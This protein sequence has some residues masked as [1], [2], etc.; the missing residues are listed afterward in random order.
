MRSVL[1]S[2]FAHRPR[3]GQPTRFRPELEPL[4]GR[5]VPSGFRQTNLVADEPG[6]APLTDPTLVNAWGISLSPT[7]GAFWVSA[8]GTGI[9]ALYIGDVNGSAV[10]RPFGVTV[11]GGAPT[12]QVFNGTGDFRVSSGTASATALF[13]FAT[14]TGNITGWN[15]TVP[16]PPPS[17]VAQLGAANPGAEY[18]GLALGNNGAGNFLYA[19]DFKGKKIDVFNSAFAPTALAGNF[20]DPGIPKQYAPFN[21]QNLGGKLYVTYAKQDKDG[22]LDGG[23]GFVSV[24]DLN[25]NFLSRLVSR[26]HLKEPWGLALAPANFGDF[27]GALLVGNHGDGSVNA[28]DPNTGDFLGKLRDETG[29]PVRID[30]LFGLAFGNG[31][32]A[33]DADALYFAAGPNGGEDGLFGKLRFVPDAGVAAG[34]APQG[35]LL[36]T[37]PVTG[38][39][40][41]TADGPARAADA[42]TD[43]VAPIPLHGPTV[44]FGAP[45]LAAPTVWIDPLLDLGVDADPV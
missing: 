17:L 45:T 40:V 11:P 1:R 38:P 9:S 12:G 36:P 21:I 34:I 10:A 39:A 3:A 8:N 13:V 2:V 4:D 7:T 24:F 43:V 15:P 19:A 32:T 28:F 25:G 20:T 30:G 6:V 22:N 27:G 44:S 29:A 42:P 14:E 33:G 41:P 26:T 23:N 35:L 31:V 5:W 37:P 18:T 16:L